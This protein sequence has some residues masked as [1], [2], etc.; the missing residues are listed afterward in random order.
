MKK[1]NNRSTRR[2]K[3]LG[4]GLNSILPIKNSEAPQKVEEPAPLSKWQEV[5]GQLSVVTLKRMIPQQ[6]SFHFLKHQFVNLKGTREIDKVQPAPCAT[7]GSTMQGDDVA[8]LAFTANSAPLVVCVRCSE[9]MIQEGVQH[10]IHP[11]QTK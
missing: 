11:I 10:I 1:Q 9:A 6:I 3:G 2:K 5:S 4:K 7:C 8:G